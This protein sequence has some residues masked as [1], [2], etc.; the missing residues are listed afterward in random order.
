MKLHRSLLLSIPVIALALT[1]AGDADACGACVPPVGEPTQVTGH[2]MLLSISQEKTTLWD[3]I[4][5][6]GDPSS[7]AWVLP[8]KGQVEVGLSSDALFNLLSDRT[9]TYVAP[10]PLNCPPPPD[11]W[12][13]GTGS[14]GAG[15]AGGG[16]ASGGVDVIAQEVVGPYETVQLSSQDPAALKNWLIGHDYEISQDIAPVIDAY[17]KEGFNFLA[18]KLVPGKGINSMRP[19]RITTLGASATLPL[20]MVAGGTGAIT[21]ITLWVFGEGK[22]DPKNFKSFTID[23][24]DVVWNWDT[25]DSNYAQLKDD[26]FKASLNLDWLMQYA[27]PAS[28]WDYEGTLQQLVDFLPDQSGYGDQSDGWAT[29]SKELQ[30]DLDDLFGGLNPNFVWLTRMNAELSRAAYTKDLELGAAA[31]QDPISSYIQTSKAIGKAPVCPVYEACPET[32]S[33]GT[34]GGTGGN[35]GN[36]GSGGLWGGFGNGANGSK[37]SGCAMGGSGDMSTALAA[38]G[39]GLGLGV[40]RRRR[41]ASK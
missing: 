14:S 11:C 7:F 39:L 29:A 26:A 3:Q 8:I 10:P 9:A 33:G 6:A 18:L 15:G 35:G 13:W 40:V 24:S 22:Y 17:V 31:S 16:D 20:R 38:I 41:R 36:G 28:P 5:Y 21:P 1:Q 37:S 32:G 19:V 23:P 27:N 30:E 25:S 12:N 4:E 2:K 34:G